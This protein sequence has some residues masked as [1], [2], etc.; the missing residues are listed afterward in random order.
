M[1]VQG[2]EMK[3]S[4]ADQIKCVERELAMRRRVYPNWVASK[5]MTQEKADHEIAAME[6]VFDTVRFYGKLGAP[7]GVYEKD[8]GRRIA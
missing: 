1:N 4:I 6:A 5:K 8:I 7:A 3:I 2:D